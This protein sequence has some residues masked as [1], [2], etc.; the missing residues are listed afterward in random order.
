MF[1]VISLKKIIKIVFIMYILF[2]VYVLFFKAKYRLSIN[3]SFLSNEHIDYCLNLKLFAT[4]KRYIK[5]YINHNVK[6]SVVLENILG[7]FILFMPFSVFANYR[8]PKLNIFRFSIIL[9]SITVSV[10]F[11]QF[12]LMIGIADIDDI[13]LN[14][15][16]AIL[17]F[18]LIRFFKYLNCLKLLRKNKVSC[19]S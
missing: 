14:F 2:L 9:L 7:N 4:I 13:F 5:A 8:F 1:K 12:I 17:I 6:L 15:T 16:G 18:I 11:L 10:E 19:K 3:I